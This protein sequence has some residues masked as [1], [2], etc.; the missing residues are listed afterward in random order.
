MKKILSI[1]FV[2]VC[3]VQLAIPTWMIYRREKTLKEGDVFLFKTQPVDPY[4]VFR[5][6]YVALDFAASSFSNNNPSVQLTRKKIVYAEL[7]Q[8]EDGF[9][10]IT[11]LHESKPAGP[12]I[13]VRIL[14][15]YD[16]NIRL[17]LPMD[18]Y[19]LEESLAP[20][21]ERLYREH[22]GRSATNTYARIR[23]RNSF[24]V[25]EDLVIDGRPVLEYTGDFPSASSHSP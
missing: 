10:I 1:L 8:D 23:V 22:S 20:E 7:E 12:G 19:Y 4:D 3:L 25:I 13:K 6:R 21:A 11:A 17:Q 24:A 14:S 16:N 5:G 18:R 2:A 15:Q 9:A